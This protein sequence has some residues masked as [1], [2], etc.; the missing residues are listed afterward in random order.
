MQEVNAGE[1]TDGEQSTSI[2]KPIDLK[3]NPDKPGSFSFNSNNTEGT[4]VGVYT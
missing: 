3:W 4:E 2:N 1:N